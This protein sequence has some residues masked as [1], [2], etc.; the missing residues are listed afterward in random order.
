[1]LYENVLDLVGNTPLVKLK[2]SPS[3]AVL[4][5][6]LEKY[7]PGGSVKDRISKAMIEDAEVQ[8]LLDRTKTVVEPTSGNTG[9]GL[10]FVCLAKG[11]DLI[12]AMPETMSMERRQILLAL[13]AKIVLTEGSKGMNGAED[14]ARG[15]VQKNPQKY[16]MP[17]QFS[18][19]AN[20]NVHYETTGEEIWRDTDGK[21]THFIAG[22]GTTGTIVG[23]SRKLRDH[24]PRVKVIGVQP[25]PETPIQGL[26][27]LQISYVPKIWDSS[28]VDEI[29]F[30][31]Q[32]DAE[33]S[34]R[35]LTLGEGIFSGI[36]TGAAYKVASDV[37]A[38]AGDGHVVFV[39]PDGGE[40]YLSTP[41]CDPERCLDCVNR[42]GLR[43][44][45]GDG[46]PIMKASEAMDALAGPRR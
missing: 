26:K 32:R 17:D 13:G 29:R 43:C 30:V 15:L 20:P 16:F 10:A 3:R 21:V 28:W 19:G 36:S 27:N 35:A 8:G 42:F 34:S 4:Y 33:D 45:Y 40:K 44:S 14:F 12:L 11:Y 46:K 25:D 2:N 22:M 31:R 9:I 1:M 24:N 38:E 5:A 23:V 41:L 18:N 6:K 7:N 37:A 39:A